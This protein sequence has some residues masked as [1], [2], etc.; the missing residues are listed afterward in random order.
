MG[1][2]NELQD[3]TEELATANETEAVLDTVDEQ[4]ENITG[5]GANDTD[6]RSRMAREIEIVNV[7]CIQFSSMVA[8]FTGLEYEGLNK[9]GRNEYRKKALRIAEAIVG[10]CDKEAKAALK[11]EKQ[12]IKKQKAEVK[13]FIKDKTDKEQKLKKQLKKSEK[14]LNLYR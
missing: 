12:N 4:I 14:R 5:I 1:S 8:E 9:T 10:K 6:I 11:K 7:T 2:E 3:V 13:K